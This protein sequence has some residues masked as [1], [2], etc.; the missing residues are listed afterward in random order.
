M[1]FKIKFR[2]PTG[3]AVGRKIASG[4]RDIML[5]DAR[6]SGPDKNL[7]L[8]L[9]PAEDNIRSSITSQQS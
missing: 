2:H 7:S 6:E 9:V 1:G 4:W 8:K 5:E 3:V